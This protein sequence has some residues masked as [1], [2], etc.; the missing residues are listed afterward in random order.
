VTF[1]QPRI[2]FYSDCDSFGGAENM[3]VALLNDAVDTGRLDVTFA[4]RTSPPYDAGVRERIRPGVPLVPLRLH[5]PEALWEPLPRW[6][7]RA[8]KAAAYGLMV[9]QLI[10]AEQ[11]VHLR[12]LFERLRP[13]IVHVNNGG[14]PG[15]SSCTP[16]ALAARQAGVP[17]V[18][19][20]VNNLAV[21]YSS[22]LRW[23]DYPLD[24]LLGSTVTKF[25]TGSQAAAAVLRRVLRLDADHVRAL[26]NG[27]Q[28]REPAEPPEAVRLRLGA[29]SDRLL[30]V[31]VGRLDAAKGHHVLL[32]AF[33]A[34]RSDGAVLAIVGEGPERER[35]EE[36]A[37]ALRLN[38][39]V[40]F[41]NVPHHHVWSLHAAADAVV[42]PSLDKEDFPY[43]V[44]EAMAM[45]KPVVATAVAGVPEQVVDGETGFLVPPNNAVDL[46]NALRAVAAHG[47]LRARMGEQAKE[48]YDRRFTA[49]IAVNRY[50]ELYDELLA[51]R[52]HP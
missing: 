15:A 7:R 43:A 14:F 17:V 5:T 40:R 34:A 39:A 10:Q 46:A 37:R 20:G 12:R 33:S 47:A 41:L 49:E 29:G 2:C 50:L 51:A 30:F 45:G 44:L 36:R 19:Y 27:I 42:L 21:G 26:P 6:P 11:T 52:A 35:L 22:P 48:R 31:S 8:I 4:Y 3:L 16:A 1:A 24:R 13:Q 9:R 28:R 23:F 18:V 25:V 38:G 32:D